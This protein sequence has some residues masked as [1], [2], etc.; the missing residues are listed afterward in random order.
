MV[1]VAVTKYPGRHPRDVDSNQ[2]PKLMP[3]AK[4]NGVPSPRQPKATLRVLPFGKAALNILTA[5]GKHNATPSPWKMRKMISCAP[6]LARPEARMKMLSTKVP[7]R[8]IMRLPTM[9]A[10]APAGSIVH[11]WPRLCA[12]SARCCWIVSYIHGSLYSR[13]S[14]S[15]PISHI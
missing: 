1:R 8:L 9:S 3:I 10:I 12:Q 6:F 11:P 14:Q 15:R 2:P 7:K 13:E 5:L 4:P